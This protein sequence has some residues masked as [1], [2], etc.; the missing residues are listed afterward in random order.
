MIYEQPLTTTA[1]TSK[2]EQ[3]F[4]ENYFP[5]KFRNALGS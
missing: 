5:L 4:G 3:S 1:N 2:I